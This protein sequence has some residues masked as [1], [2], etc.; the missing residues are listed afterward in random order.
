[1]AVRNDWYERAIDT[2]ERTVMLHDFGLRYPAPY[3]RLVQVKAAAWPGR[4]GV[5]IARQES[6]RTPRALRRSQRAD[7][8]DAITARWVSARHKRPSHDFD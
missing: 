2:A 8:I 3:R 7:A 5:R 6:Y 1:L 4:G